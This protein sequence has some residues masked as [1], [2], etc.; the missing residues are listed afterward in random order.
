M[1]LAPDSKLRMMRPTRG[2]DMAQSKRHGARLRAVHL[3]LLLPFIAM[4]WVGFYNRAEPSIAGIPF[5]YWFQ[6]LWIPLG[7]VLLWPV[8]RAEDRDNDGRRH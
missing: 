2:A 1:T 6:L 3:L 8:Y 5:F 4:L 7:A